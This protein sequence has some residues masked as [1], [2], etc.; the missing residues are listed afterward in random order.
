MDLF[1]NVKFI[2]EVQK[3]SALWDVRSLDYADRTNRRKCWKDLVEI[4]YGNLT[5]LSE[6]EENELGES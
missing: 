2:K 3:R 4:F 5:D 6:A 1:D